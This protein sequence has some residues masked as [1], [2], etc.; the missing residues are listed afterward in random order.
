[1]SEKIEDILKRA[2]GHTS[3]T[4]SPTSSKTEGE[5]LAGNPDCEI[6]GGLGYY[7]RDL[8]VGDPEFGKIYTCSCRVGQL[9]QHM[10]ADLYR[11]SNLDELSHLTF[12]NF[13]PRGQI[14]LGAAQADSLERA[15]NHTHRFARS[16]DGWLV[17]QGDYGCGKTH[18]AAAAANFVVDLGIPTLFL[19]VP[20]LLDTLRFS[21]NKPDAPFED[22]FQ[23]IRQSPLL[24]MDDFGTENATPWAQEKLF[25]ILNY[26]YVNEL[27]LLVTTNLALDQ[28][29]GRIKSRLQDPNL[30]TRVHIL[31]PDYRR[32]ADDT[33][34]SELSSLGLM[35]ERRFGN[36]SL[37]ENENLEAE[38]RKRLERAFQAAR[39]FAENPQGWL[40]LQGTYGSGKTHLA[41]AIANFRAGK[42][43][44]PLF[45][46]VPD[47]LDHLRATF[48][49]EST[50]SYDRRFNE[51]KT[52][53]L[54]VLD[55]LGT[56]SMTNWVKEKLYQLFNYRYNAGL[57]TVITTADTLSEIDP[58]I[59]SRMLDRRICR[60]FVITAPPFTGSARRRG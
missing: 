21:Y 42:G 19:T 10:Q 41:A 34:H 22:R 56:Q 24:V 9:K 51:V 44:P 32:P 27:P 7:R 28:M 4:S 43:I 39:D 45:V 40:V 23:E 5:S 12:D 6:C 38:E 20:D 59:R 2:A 50:T 25:Q 17:L 57:P 33:G 37:R 8:P 49:P 54:L 1:M 31:A 15:Y 14:G 18:L 48:N 35:N 3:K 30:V 16:L 52:A 29:E 36:F 46:M 60:I 11:M 58:R 26:R 53:P 47:L 13:Q 55:D